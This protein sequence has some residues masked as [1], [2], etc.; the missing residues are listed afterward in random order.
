MSVR[1]CRTRFYCVCN[2][3]LGTVRIVGNIPELG[4]IFV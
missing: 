4:I 1:K 2:E 3:Q